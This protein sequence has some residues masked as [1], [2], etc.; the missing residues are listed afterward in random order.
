MATGGG[1][2]TTIDVGGVNIIVQGGNTN[3]ETAKIS[4]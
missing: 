3:E 2:G 1:G 4:T